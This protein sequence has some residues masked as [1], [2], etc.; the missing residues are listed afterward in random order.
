MADYRYSAQIIGR[1]SG[2][3]AVA[4]AA[5]R[6]GASLA[7]E[8]T[9][10]VHDFSR[11]HGVLHTEIMAPDNAPDWMSDRARLWNA[12]EA[13][14]KRKDSQLSREIQLSLPHELTDSQRVELLQSFI[15]EQFISRGVIADIAIHAPD[16]K[17]DERNH[18]AHVMLTMREL[19]GEGFGKKERTTT[20]EKKAA[21]E[22]EREAWANHVNRAL[23]R[24]QH[25]DRVD[26]RSYERRGIDREATWHRGNAA[27][28][29]EKRGESSRIVTDNRAIEQRNRARNDN[30]RSLAET[31]IDADRMRQQQARTV[32]DR[33]AAIR[34]AQLI[35]TIDLER[36]QHRQT[37]ALGLLLER[38]YGA[39]QRTLTAAAAQL[40]KRMHAATGF[41]KVWQVVRNL[42]GRTSADRHELDAIKKTLI[43][44]RGRTEE[45]TR[46]LRQ[47]HEAERAAQKA[48]QQK[49][50]ETTE[51][52]VAAEFEQ[53][54]REAVRER[55]QEQAR[56]KAVRALAGR[57]RP[58]TDPT[59]PPR[60]RR[61]RQQQRNQV[62]PALDTARPTRQ[63]QPQPELKPM[64][65]EFDSAR[66]PPID[67]PK[68]P[69]P[70]APE[71]RRSY[72]S[73]PAPAPTPAGAVNIPPKQE[74]ER[75]KVDKVQEWAKSPEGRA[76]LGKEAPPPQ[77]RS[78]DKA[79]AP[80]PPAPQ[81]AR[82]VPAPNEQSG[83]T[84]A[85]SWATK[86]AVRPEPR[87]T[88]PQEQTKPQEPSRPSLAPSWATKG[89]ERK[90]I[91][92]E[93][94]KDRDLD[95]ER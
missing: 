20:D 26:H 43:D 34:S 83:K 12:V 86:G 33:Q 90:P 38:Q 48:A 59:R 91:N 78:F 8:R 25:Q 73:Q 28:Q 80:E 22:R 62:K 18:H 89:V 95:R 57:I 79:A 72:A 16:P 14:E 88:P 15:K 11:R 24:H 84:L 74:H 52:T 9:G 49:Q 30:H 61:T 1:S 94:T 7:D 54:R 56:A 37:L 64:K 58:Q 82:P 81:P 35:Q 53:K 27:S 40:E 2:R 31:K 32:A 21:L 70:K 77:V 93:R 19:T 44:I 4:A 10:L 41:K 36:R 69:E 60:P 87:P 23:E 63:P 42:T 68:A 50:L 51:R 6:A 46:A 17:G 45:A 55:R 75:P 29:M 47:Q 67:Q 66:T 71:P 65:R 39:H 3:S 76:V 85:P 92:T 13:A 5:Y